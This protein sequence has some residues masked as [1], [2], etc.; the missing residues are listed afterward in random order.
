METRLFKS[1]TL[2]EMA[3]WLKD[4]LNLTDLQITG[5]FNG[6]DI[7]SPYEYEFLMDG[8]TVAIYCDSD[9]FYAEGIST[10]KF[11]RCESFDEMLN[12]VR[13]AVRS[14]VA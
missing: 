5:K 14:E 3:R 10:G 9:T 11:F 2:T 12:A 13:E 6:L 8:K 1:M 7:R 4:K